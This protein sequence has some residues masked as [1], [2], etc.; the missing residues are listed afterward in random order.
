MA[1]VVIGWAVW[2]SG[3]SKGRPGSDPPTAAGGSAA[4]QPDS[5]FIGAPAPDFSLVLFDTGKTVTLSDLKGRPVI[6]DFFASWC[7]SCRA[8]A[9]TLQQ[10]GQDYADQGVVLLGVA[11]HDSADGL[12]RFKRELGLTYL[13]GL[14][15]G[16]GIAASYQ[17]ISIPTFVFIDREGRIRTT[18]VGMVGE[19]RLA[20]EAEALL[21]S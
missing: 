2:E 21:E 3:V 4:D 11:I 8:E 14:D 6:L 5:D 18:I 15:E 9:P 13:M 17:A 19:D 7:A 1:V 12:Q 20:A 10:F 16:G